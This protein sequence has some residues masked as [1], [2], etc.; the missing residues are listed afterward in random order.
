[1]INFL[2]TSIF[3]YRSCQIDSIKILGKSLAP[4]DETQAP[5]AGRT[6][7][8]R[9]HMLIH[10]LVSQDTT[11]TACHLSTTHHAALRAKLTYFQT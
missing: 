5:I 10:A 8:Y 1:M 4:R 6:T 2:Q 7:A 9:S 11:Y 3:L